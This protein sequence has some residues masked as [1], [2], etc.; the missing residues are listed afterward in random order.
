MTDFR[1]KICG[2]GQYVADAIS[3]LRRELGKFR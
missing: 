1:Q 3:S 2:G